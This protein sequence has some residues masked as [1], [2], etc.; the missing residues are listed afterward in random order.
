MIPG[1]RVS[2]ENNGMRYTKDVDQLSEEVLIALAKK[3]EF[4]L[5]CEF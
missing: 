4:Y 3:L 5:S 1:A 2:S